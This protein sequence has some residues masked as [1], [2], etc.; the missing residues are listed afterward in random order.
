MNKMK[1]MILALVLMALFA[2]AAQ[3]R[4]ALAD[5]TVENIQE[6]IPVEGVEV[7]TP[8]GCEDLIHISGRI[9]IQVHITELDNGDMLYVFNG[10]PQNAVAVG[11]E[12]G[13]VYHGVG[14]TGYVE[15]TL[16][17]GESVHLV[18]VFMQVPSVGVQELLHTTI[19]ANGEMT[20]YMEQIVEPGFSCTA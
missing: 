19:N 20:N 2:P 10:T 6:Y 13:N 15:R 9:H 5:A 11:E 12:T 17:P 16:G 7:H 18:N 8:E 1:K 14:H 4:V 3:G